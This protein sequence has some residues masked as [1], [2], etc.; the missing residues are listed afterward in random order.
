MEE[1]QSNIIARA[2]M[3]TG[4][5]IYS[6]TNNCENSVPPKALLNAGMKNT[7]ALLWNHFLFLFY[8]AIDKIHSP[9]LT[10]YIICRHLKQPETFLISRD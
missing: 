3:N 2:A 9:K 7:L 10:E 8:Y 6:T 4:I 1:V 5:I